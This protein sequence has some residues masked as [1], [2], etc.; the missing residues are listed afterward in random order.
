MTFL[1]VAGVNKKFGGIAALTDCTFSIRSKEISCIVGP[2]GAGKTSVFNVITGF[3]APDTGTIRFKGQDLTKASR[4]ER[5]E[6][7]IARTF[8]NL[9]LF[10]ELSV[11][12]N[13]MT[14]LASEAGNNPLTAIFRP[15]HTEAILRAKR[16]KAREFI[17]TVGLSHKA[18]DLAKNL[19]Y[20]QKKL[21]CVARVL[22]TDAE[23]LLLDEPTSG[24]AAAALDTMVEMIHKLK[25][26][27]KSLLIV[28][29][30]TQIVR[31]IADEVLFFHRG[32]LLAQGKTEDIVSDKELGSIY[33]GGGH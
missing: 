26:S 13:V 4:H 32:T 18:D 9:R 25:A 2:N 19:S 7:G 30:N 31:R 3:I 23:L 8:Q 14:C 21:L 24:L 17:E 29:H 16:E 27:G 5:I 15:I 11:M 6:A 10:E 20:G 12:D 22:A 33:F 28:E 1:D